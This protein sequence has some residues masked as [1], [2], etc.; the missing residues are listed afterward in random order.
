MYPSGDRY[1]ALNIVGKYSLLP[2]TYK[3]HVDKKIQINHYNT[4]ADSTIKNFTIRIDTAEAD[5]INMYD[6][7]TDSGRK[8]ISL[9]VSID[10]SAKKV[11]VKWN[12]FTIFDSS[13]IIKYDAYDMELTNQNYTPVVTANLLLPPNC[14]AGINTYKSIIAAVDSN[15]IVK[16]TDV[17]TTETNGQANMVNYNNSCLNSIGYGALVDRKKIE[18]IVNG[19]SDYGVN[20]KVDQSEFAAGPND[21]VIYK[22]LDSIITAKPIVYVLVSDTS[23]TASAQKFKRELEGKGFAVKPVALSSFS[24]NS[25]IYYYRDAQQFNADK[26]NNLYKKYYPALKVQAHLA[27]FPP[28]QA[29]GARRLSKGCRR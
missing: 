29:L 23:L 5:F 16:E 28:G 3:K 13:M 15:I 18:R 7:T 20:L 9:P 22:A 2:F 27:K 8:M 10:D 21:I 25:D 26:I 6:Y 12:Q 11:I 19:F 17:V 14:K 24:Y 4:A 1:F